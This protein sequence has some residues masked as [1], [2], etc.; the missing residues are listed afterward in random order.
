MDT[1]A[2]GEHDAE[3]SE[4]HAGHENNEE[5]IEALMENV[6]WQVTEMYFAHENSDRA[7]W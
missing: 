2:L 1:Q 5:S 4:G 7:S 3:V 6:D